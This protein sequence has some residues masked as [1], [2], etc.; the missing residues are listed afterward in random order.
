[1]TARQ[2]LKRSIKIFAFL[3]PLVILP[4]LLSGIYLLP[5]TGTWKPQENTIN[6]DASP[7]T[8]LNSGEWF[9]DFEDDPVGGP[10]IENDPFFFE[11]TEGKCTV[12]TKLPD[13]EVWAGN[14]SFKGN[15]TH[16][17]Y[18]GKY[19]APNN[20]P[21]W[22][23]SGYYYEDCYAPF[24]GVGFGAAE[25]GWWAGSTPR[26]I[27]LGFV[28]IG[29]MYFGEPVNRI[30]YASGSGDNTNAPQ[31]NQPPVGPALAEGV[32]HFV[33]VVGNMVTRTYWFQV[34]EWNQ[35]T[36]EMDLIYSSDTDFPNG[37]P[38]VTYTNPDG[39]PMVTSANFVGLS[40]TAQYEDE[41][42]WV[43]D[44]SIIIPEESL[45]QKI[46]QLSITIMQ[47]EDSVFDKNP[48]QRR[49]T[50]GNMI[51]E[52]NT[53]IDAEAYSGAYE[54]ILH[55]L[56]P[57]LTGLKTDEIEV[58]WGNGVFKNPWIS[59]P[60]AQEQCRTLCNSILLGI[61]LLM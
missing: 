58:P 10:P 49:A 44:I 59:D 7:L 22:E 9:F 33:R 5:P 60:N 21:T 35:T 40:T 16:K 27:Y 20:A 43:D 41:A 37:I 30:F 17:Y 8:T 12:V 57:K 45:S 52:L 47:F 48:T 25:S 1:M 31:L 11:L 42:T 26:D 29:N 38:F 28:F 36:S 6:Q 34:S 23:V 51:Q 53:L 2:M 50:L 54:K 56:K 13:N 4:L 3:M 55:D 14:Q 24:S 61:K 46:N 39:T 18:L 32:W 19:L 15:G